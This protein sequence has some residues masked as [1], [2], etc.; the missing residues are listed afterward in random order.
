MTTIFY[1]MT[2]IFIGYE[3]WSITHTHVLTELSYGLKQYREDKA[4][5]PELMNGCVVATF[6][7]LYLSWSIIGLFSSN[8][9]FFLMLLVIGVISNLFRRV[10]PKQMSLIIGIDAFLS[11]VVLCVI[12][13]NYF[14]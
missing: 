6:S 5:T 9:K 14:I 4:V 13:I 11:V 10:F 3:I 7:M 1:L 2:L 12:F 8:A